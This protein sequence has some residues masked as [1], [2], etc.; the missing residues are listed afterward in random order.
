MRWLLDGQLAEYIFTYPPY[1]LIY[2]G[3]TK[4]KMTIKNDNMSASQFQSFLI[5]AFSCLYSSARPGAAIYICHADSE[6]NEFREAMTAAGW[7][8]K[9]CLIWVKNQFVI[10]RQDYQWQHEPILYGWR[11]DGPHAFYGGRRQ[12][13]ILE[14]SPITIR[15]DG[16]TQLICITVGTEQVVIRAKEAAVVSQANDALMTTWRFEKPIRNGDHPTMKPIPLCARAIQ[17]SSCPEEIV[18]DSFGGSGSTLMAAE[19]TDRICYTMELDP[20]YADVILRR[21]EAFTGQT[22]EKLS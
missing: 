14:D 15:P 1:N 22:A 9:Q 12:G 18:L 4:D 20:I 7:T 2:N 21:W 19:Q 17:N 6:G 3:D 13:T 16:D 8:L 11:T 10:G 5:V